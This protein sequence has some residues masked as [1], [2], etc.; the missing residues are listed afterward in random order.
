MKQRAVLN[1]DF[2]VTK[3]FGYLC[4]NENIDWDTVS[5]EILDV[6]FAISGEA[7]GIRRR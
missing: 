4:A 2:T 3:K 7:E 6:T 1:L 5:D